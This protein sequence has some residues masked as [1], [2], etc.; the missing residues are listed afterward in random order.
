MVIFSI[1]FLV[2]YV[3]FGSNWG[4]CFMESIDN[5]KFIDIDEV[6]HSKNPGL[7]KVLPRFIISYLKKIVHQDEINRFIEL[8]GHKTEFDFVDAI[9]NEFE[10][11]VTFE[12]LENVPSTAGFIMAANHPLGGLDAMALV[13]VVG[14]KRKDIRFIVNDIL[15]QL[16]NLSGIF[17][18]V[19]KHGKNSLETLHTLDQE[20]ASGQGMLIFPAGLVSRKQHG[21]IRD[22]E[23]KKSFIT[24]SR[25]HNLPVI[26]VYIGGN[27][28]A[29]FYNLSKLRTRIGIKANIEMLYLAD[30]MYKQ[31]NHTISIIFGKPISSEIFNNKK[32]ERD[33]AQLVKHHIYNLGREGSLVTFNTAD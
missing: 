32:P 11:N 24:K 3:N 6:F 10:V 29:F 19:N 28:S 31:K 33:W 27:N 21:Q 14:T 8:N 2:K 17:V 20:Y 7:Y 1:P 26:P 15:L 13:Q 9:I 23:W 5:K 30:E 4:N 12:G 25:K 16:K 22:L 18:G